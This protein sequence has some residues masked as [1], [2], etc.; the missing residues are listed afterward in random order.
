M[1]A[2]MNSTLRLAGLVVLT[3]AMA[4]CLGSGSGNV[5]TGGGGGTTPPKSPFAAYDAAYKEATANVLANAPTSDMP[6]SGS[7]KYTGQVMIGQVNANG[8]GKV[9]DG[10]LGDLTVNVGFANGV[11]STVNGKVDNIR[12]KVGDKVTSRPGTLTTDY[13]KGLGLPSTVAIMSNTI[14]VPTQGPRTL[15]TGSY[16]LTMGAPVTAQN[17][18]E[19]GI[20]GDLVLGVSG[21]FTG[22]GA[23]GGYGPASA[24][25]FT[26]TVNAGGGSGTNYIK[27]N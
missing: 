25:L 13:A 23:K 21:A 26:G 3:T 9:A 4:G 5:P 22:Q 8:R 6:T 1:T 20:D 7:A 19:L 18:P 10:M 24:L 11:N 12:V 15:R 16:S 17:L 27:R 14:N 2:Q